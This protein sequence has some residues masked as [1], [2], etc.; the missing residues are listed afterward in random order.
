MKNPFLTICFI[1]MMLLFL[2]C[3]KDTDRIP[4]DI[5]LNNFVWKGLNSYYYWQ[6]DVADLSDTRFSNQG[7]LNN[8]LRSF[9]TPEELFQHLR[10][11]PGVVD[12]FSWIVDDY[13]A[14]ENSFQGIRLTNGMQFKLYYNKENT[15][16]VYGVVYY[17]IPG[18]NA[19]TQGVLRGAVFSAIDDT[20]ITVENYSSLLFGE[21]RNYTVNMSDF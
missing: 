3:T 16:N 14:L 18:S 9:L 17:V 19:A 1:S 7:A 11:Q 2:N 8:F 20:Q 5:E 21:N 6:S 15:T 4:E 12:R 13:I 10:F